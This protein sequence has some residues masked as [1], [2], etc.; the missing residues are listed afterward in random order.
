[1]FKSASLIA[2]FA[3]M[4]VSFNASA[5]LIFSEDFS[6][7][8]SSLK[9]SPDIVWQDS[10]GGSFEVYGSGGAGRRGM[11]G[12]FDHDND[13]LTPEIPLYGAI[14]VNDDRGDVLLTATFELAEEVFP[15]SVGTLS[16]YAGVR[17]NNGT[18]ASV[19]IYNVTQGFSLT[20]ELSPTLGN[21][22]WVHNS[23]DFNWGASNQGDQIQIRWTG[24]GSN[25]AN[26]Q[27]VSFVSLSSS[28]TV[29]VPEP[30]THL[31]IGFAILGLALR[32][33]TNK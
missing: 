1:M 17:G 22:N 32:F 18:G 13:P 27:E 24:G 30:A 10:D 33:R 8:S 5:G 12:T 7:G 19:E 3:A 4:A 28:N 25:S 26:G 20:G 16:Y 23:F 29:A 31:L 9:N 6:S 15:S 14:E 11:S 21:V 2:A